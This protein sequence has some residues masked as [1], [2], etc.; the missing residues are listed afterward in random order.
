MTRLVAVLALAGCLAGLAPWA[1][2]ALR[3]GFHLVLGRE[4]PATLADLELASRT[5]EDAAREISAALAA[6]DPDLA[7]SA[8]EWADARGLELAPELRARVAAEQTDAAIALRG[9]RSFGSGFV[10]GAPDDLPGL[11]GAAAGDLT[12]WG[13]LRDAAREGWHY[14]QGEEV[15][16][17]LLGLSAA[18]LALTAGTYATL[19]GGA[20]ARMGLSLVKAAKR[21]GRLSAAFGAY[22]GR[23][24]RES[25]DL[26][27]LRRAGGSFDPAALK[28]V[29]RPQGV[30]RI[31]ALM[32]DL[33]TVQAKAGTRAALAGLAVVEDGAD[34]RRLAKLSE[35][36]GGQT[37]FVL[38]ALG[39]GALAITGALL[40]FVWWGFG[41]VVWLV[42]LIA[43]FNGVCV[44]L[45][46]L[47][48]R[49]PGRARSARRRDRVARIAPPRGAKDGS[50]APN[51]AL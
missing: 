46:R 44:A 12:V 13:D 32:S 15:D 40:S 9:A 33:G 31:G 49:R 1:L 51:R 36:K 43:A 6:G 18:G 8:Q 34:V 39:R 38:R 17:L 48:W 28:G 37:L 5:P 4:D 47:C 42:W 20:P 23:L 50:V 29:V 19:G 21:T 16:T 11:A 25:L 2:P 22:L 7:A 41:A 30:A 45:A 3:D 26:G 27:A 10:T 35:K 14:A 24:V